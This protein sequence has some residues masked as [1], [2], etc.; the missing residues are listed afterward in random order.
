MILMYQNYPDNF[1]CNSLMTLLPWYS[2]SNLPNGGKF[3]PSAGSRFAGS[4]GVFQQGQGPDSGSQQGITL[5]NSTNKNH[6]P[7][8]GLPGE[9]IPRLLLHFQINVQS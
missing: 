4:P 3:G 5:H 6:S 7:T 1:N 2:G 9:N 8:S